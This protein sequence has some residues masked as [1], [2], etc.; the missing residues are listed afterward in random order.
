MARK[1]TET[2]GSLRW[3]Q[4]CLNDDFISVYDNPMRWDATRPHI[5]KLYYRYPLSLEW[6]LGRRG[7]TNWT[8]NWRISYWLHLQQSVP[9]SGTSIRTKRSLGATTT[10]PWIKIGNHSS[11][12]TTG[13]DRAD[14]VQLQLGLVGCVQFVHMMIQKTTADQ[15]D[16]CEWG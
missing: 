16:E 15:T 3:L 8:R 12:N 6:D 1:E 10:T 11:V 5:G 13:H 14:P 9:D 2:K 7:K 4:L